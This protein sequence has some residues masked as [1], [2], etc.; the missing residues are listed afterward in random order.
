M[1]RSN[2]VVLLY[3]QS[4]FPHQH[5]MI[6]YQ[7]HIFESYKINIYSA[8]RTGISVLCTVVQA[9][10]GPEP[11]AGHPPH[12]LVRHRAGFLRGGFHSCEYNKHLSVVRNAS[13]ELSATKS[14]LFC[15]SLSRQPLFC[16]RPLNHQPVVHTGV[17][18]VLPVLRIGSL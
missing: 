3:W 16:S 6:L 12:L 11:A 5:R 18:S 17:C 7:H 8:L 14:N 15:R 2:Q 13:I 4:E 10:E 1:L 9:H